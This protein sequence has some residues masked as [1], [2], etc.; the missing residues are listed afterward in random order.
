[1]NIKAILFDYDGVI[2]DSFPS[3][4]EVYKKMCNKFN[5]ECPQGIEKFRKLYGYNYGEC[6]KNLGIKEQYL[7]QTNEIYKN[8]IV[9]KNHNI[10]N[11]IEKVI[12][13]LSK[14]YKLFLVSASYKQEVLEKLSNYKLIE[15]FQE[16][17][18]GAD[19]KIKKSK[20]IKNI[21]KDNN[22]L[23][24]E[25]I[26]I[27]DRTIDYD[28]AKKVGLDNDN[29]IIV[30]YGWG[31]NKERIKIKNIAHSPDDILKIINDSIK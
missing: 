27:G 29:I 11:G 21:I 22:F 13:D 28:I 26:S 31:Y 15:Y 17:Y 24:K 18:C 10:F 2:V 8:E 12:I 6:L 14:K 9:K 5:V 20:I 30:S 4:F 16:I 25:V 1:M 7:N 3:V 19:Q 23:K